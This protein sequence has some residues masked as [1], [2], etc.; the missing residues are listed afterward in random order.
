[1][2]VS[3][4]PGFILFWGQG[5]GAALKPILPPDPFF[6]VPPSKTTVFSANEEGRRQ[7]ES[8]I[9]CSLMRQHHSAPAGGAGSQEERGSGCWGTALWA[10]MSA[11]IVG[12]FSSKPEV[13]SNTVHLFKAISN[14]SCLTS[15]KSYLTP[16]NSHQFSV[17]IK[18]FS[19]A[20]KLS[21]SF[22]LSLLF[23]KDTAGMFTYGW[24]YIICIIQKRLLKV[25]LIFF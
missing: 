23:I 13:D 22:C 16:R 2:K 7:Q 24:T 6:V 11:S 5:A 25:L 15:F 12:I 9:S 20:E 14:M 4:Y 17:R 19:K 21:L 1:M 3:G 8:F 10:Q 18:E